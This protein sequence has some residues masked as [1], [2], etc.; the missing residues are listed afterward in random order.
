[1]G[2]DTSKYN[3]TNPYQPQNL[4]DKYYAYLDLSE[5]APCIHSIQ[6]LPDVRSRLRILNMVAK[7][8]SFMV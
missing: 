8:L 6:V 5:F 2:Y 1:M 3:R 7:M 4:N